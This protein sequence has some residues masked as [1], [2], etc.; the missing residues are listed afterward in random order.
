LPL[1][2]IAPAQP[3]DQVFVN[4]NPAAAGFRPRE[5][6][7]LGALAHFLGVHVQKGGG[8]AERQGLHA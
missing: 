6:A 5:V 2:S 8:L 4:E 1:Q 3:G 7:A